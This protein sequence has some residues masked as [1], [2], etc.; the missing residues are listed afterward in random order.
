MPLPQPPMSLGSYANEIDPAVRNYFI[1]SYDLYK[2]KLSTVAKVM[3]QDRSSD[4]QAGI[5]GLG[6]FQL[7]PEGTKYPLDTFLETYKTSFVQQKYGLSVAVTMEMMKWDLSGS[8]SAKSIGSAMAKS[9]INKSEELIA[10]VYNN[11]FNTSFT[12]LT[13]LK[14][15][16]STDHTRVD[17]GTSRSNASSTSIPLTHDNLRAAITQ[18]RTQRDSRGKIASINPRILLVPPALEHDALVITKSANRSGTTDNDINVNSMREYTGGELKVVVWEYLT[19]TTAWFLIDP[20]TNMITYKWGDKPQVG[21]LDDTTG[22]QEDVI[23]FK[24]H[25]M[26]A[27]GWGDPLG[28]FGSPGTGAAYAS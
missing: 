18:M 11:G 13:D 15:L 22:K 26:A 2:S 19:S 9:A 20:N 16:F 21:E 28:A 24:G 10:S 23:Y 6:S 14:P 4:V 3:T 27:T 7:I 5:S 25:F 8:M 1:E 12:S 17:G